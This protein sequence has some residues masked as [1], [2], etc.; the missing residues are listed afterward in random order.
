RQSLSRQGIPK[1]I[2]RECA[3]QHQAKQKA[4]V[5]VGPQRDQRQ[6][7]ERGRLT[8]LAG[9]HQAVRPDQHDGHRQHMRT[10]QQMPAGQHQ[11]R[12]GDHAR[13]DRRQRAVEDGG[14]QREAGGGA[15][16]GQRCRA[17]P[18]GEVIGLRQ[19]DLCQP[20]RRRPRRTGL[21]E[22]IDVDRRQ[23]A[24]VEDPAADGNLPVGVGI[25]QQPV[26]NEQ[27]QRIDAARHP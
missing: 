17:G 13:V 20:R 9:G 15:G 24:M 3:G 21:G 23:R 8:A 12:K 4:A 26:A 16:R 25:G 19:Q 6:Q 5:Q 10:G 11:R 18:P 27:Q 1:R 7:P 22:R 14:Q 2:E